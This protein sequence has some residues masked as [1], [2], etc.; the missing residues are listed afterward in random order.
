MPT[1]RT[2]Q[3]RTSDKNSFDDELRRWMETGQEFSP[4]NQTAFFVMEEE[5][6]LDIWRELRSG[7]LADWKKRKRPGRLYIQNYIEEKIEYYRLKKLEC[8]AIE[9]GYSLED[10]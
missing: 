5:E 10:L 9:A 4:D 2:K 1:N 7:L 3:F 6:L 8:P